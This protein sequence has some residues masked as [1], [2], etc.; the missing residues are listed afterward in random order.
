FDFNQS[1]NLATAFDSAT[2]NAGMLRVCS[3]TACGAGSVIAD[4]V[5]AIVYSMGS[6]WASIA[7]ASAEEQAND[8]GGPDFVSTTY[9]EENFDDL[10]VWLSP[11]TLFSRLVSTGSFPP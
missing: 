4:S 10:L 1:A 3:T 2:F 9:S 6:N 5:P 11:Y 7:T 8:D